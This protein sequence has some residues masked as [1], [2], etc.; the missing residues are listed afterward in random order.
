[1]K[2]Y[3]SIWR[4]ILIVVGIF[5]LFSAILLCY[6]YYMG[7]EELIPVLL[8]FILGTSC[9]SYAQQYSRSYQQQSSLDTLI[10]RNQQSLT[11]KGKPD[12]GYEEEGVELDASR[13]SILS[14]RDDYLS[15]IIDGNGN[16]WDFF[17]VGSAKDIEQHIRSLLSDSEKE[18]IQF[19][20]V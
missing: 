1:L 14:I 17:V 11:F 13:L 20:H 9:I 7:H 8:L 4:V 5:S 6:R 3:Q 10:T 15:V 12:N 18:K 19:K 2:E 16:G